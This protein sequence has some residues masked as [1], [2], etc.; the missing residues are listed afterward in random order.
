MLRLK[1]RAIIFVSGLA[2]AL[3]L[4]PAY[5]ATITT[6][7]DSATWQAAVTGVQLIN[8][9]GL[10][11]ANSY[12]TYPGGIPTGTSVQ[13]TGVSG[14]TIGVM[15]THGFSWADFNSNDAGFATGG[16]QSV[17]ITL[18]AGVTA[19]GIDLFTSPP[20]VVYT[21]TVLSTPFVVPTFSQ[22]TRAFFGVTSDTPI[23]TVTLTPQ[24]G[25]SYA[26]FDNF[27]WGTAQIS[28]GQVPEAGTSLLIGTGL[29]GF[30]IIRIR[31]TA[32]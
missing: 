13:F 14:T 28:G 8:F 22:P 29:L 30:A 21:A 3:T 1:S 18:P 12:A 4:T 7:S 27:K 5:S 32:R 16:T 24:S 10:A 25:A 11:P 26:F 23:G 9:E 17:Q 19:F 31:R 6:Y 20:S 2:L 15:D